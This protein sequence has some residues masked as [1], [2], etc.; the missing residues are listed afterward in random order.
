MLTAAIIFLTLSSVSWGWVALLYWD[1]VQTSHYGKTILGWALV[2]GT[3]GVLLQL[4][5]LIA[6]LN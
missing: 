1:S 3:I 2:L 5:G 4:G 6:K